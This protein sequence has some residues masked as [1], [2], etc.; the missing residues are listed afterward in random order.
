MAE[1]LITIVPAVDGLCDIDKFSPDISKCI[2]HTL[3]HQQ[4]EQ[5]CD[6]YVM[7]TD[8]NGIKELN[9]EHRK[10]DRATDVLSFPMLELTP[11]EPIVVGPLELDP[12]TGR[13]MLGDMVISVERARAQAE[14]YGH[15]L[16]RELCFLAVHSTLHLLG[17]DHEKSEEE[18]AIQFGL[19]EE[20]LA[21]CG[22][23]RD[24]EAL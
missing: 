14:E 11:G 16:T 22:I 8:D 10:I 13:L 4:V 24:A 15:S 20:I 2:I 3:E 18:E 9:A 17:Y 12:E 19:Q 23:T 1:H 7:L 6:V 21:E 5:A